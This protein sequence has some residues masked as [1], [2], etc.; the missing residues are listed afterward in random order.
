MN[1]RR[2][3]LKAMMEPVAAP[4]RT[5]ADTGIQAARSPLKA[6]SLKSMGLS[7]K[8]LS[9]DAAEAQ[10]LREQIAQG[11]VV[12]EVDPSA[13]IPSFVR[14]RLADVSGESEEALIESIAAHG[15]QVPVLLRPDPT[16]EGRY[17]IAY[18]HRRVAALRKLGRKVKAIVRP[19]TDEELFVAQGKENL[20]RQDLS[21]IERALFAKNLEDRGVARETLMAVFAVHK[22]NLSTMISV[23]RRIP[24]DLIEWIGA[25]P[26]AG[27][28][29]WEALA[30][31]LQDD[32]DRWRQ[33]LSRPGVSQLR[34]DQRFAAVFSAMSTPTSRME[35]IVGIKGEDIATVTRSQGKFRV[36][37]DD[38]RTPEFAAFLVQELP[39]IHAAFLRRKT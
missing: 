9:D 15:Q 19:L 7:L 17:Q 37:V 39:A 6:G 30:N 10:A 32:A 38:R 29:R 22:G 34:S 5:E 33:I 4:N 24:A 26:K 23:V 8:S 36:V 21:F 3:A 28:P 14:D 1:K 12:I 25:A 11:E 35:Q 16:G 20:E 27:R 18:G 13:V 31:L 2:D